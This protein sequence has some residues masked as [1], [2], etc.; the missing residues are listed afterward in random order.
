MT[1][2]TRDDPAATGEPGARRG[3][4]EPSLVPE[5]GIGRPLPEQP[6]PAPKGSYV[7]TGDRVFKTLAVGSGALIVIIIAAI[8]LFLLIQ[9]IPPLRD[10]QV[11]FLTSREWD[12]ADP[13]NL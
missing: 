7:R 10:N 1:E 8:G 12:T 2:S 11:S 4:P 5:A 9:A 6:T 3:G 13:N